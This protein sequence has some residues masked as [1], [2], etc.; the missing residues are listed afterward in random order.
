MT[1][2]KSNYKEEI[3]VVYTFNELDGSGV[4][5]APM[6][7]HHTGHMTPTVSVRIKP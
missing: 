2:L 5:I 4:Y 7:Q 3:R 1:G 6:A